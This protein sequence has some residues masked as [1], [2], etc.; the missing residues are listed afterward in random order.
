MVALFDSLDCETKAHRGLQL[1]TT[2]G[3]QPLAQPISK[4]QSN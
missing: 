3:T 2:K 4:P 1:S